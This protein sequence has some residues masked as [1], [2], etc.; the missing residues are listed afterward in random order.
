M[1]LVDKYEMT[2]Q[3]EQTVEEVV[4]GLL[5]LYEQGRQ[6]KSDG[7]KEKWEKLVEDQVIPLMQKLYIVRQAAEHSLDLCRRPF[8]SESSIL[9]N[10]MISRTIEKQKDSQAAEVALTWGRMAYSKKA[11]NVK[12]AAYF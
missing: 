12:I 4:P 9:L 5:Q 10:T 6:L 3:M 2:A 8:V 11:L 7:K 1:E